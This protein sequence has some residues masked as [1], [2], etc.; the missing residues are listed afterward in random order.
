MILEAHRADAPGAGPITL[1]MEFAEQ[2]GEGPTPYETLF[3]AA[4]AGD[5]S[6]FTR[7]PTIEEAWR[8]VQPLLD[9]NRRTQ[10]YR[11]GSWGPAAAN[12]LPEDGGPWRRPWPP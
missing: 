4:L 8:I 6:L 9:A 5:R 12:K 2:G 3:E 11:R 7:Q 10:S 1:E